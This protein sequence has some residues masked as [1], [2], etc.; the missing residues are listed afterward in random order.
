MAGNTEFHYI[1]IDVGTGSARACVIDHQGNIVGLASQ[2]IKTWQP[3]PEFYEQSTKDIWNTSVRQS[4][5]L[6]RKQVCS[7]PVSEVLLSMPHAL[8]LFSAKRPTIR[9]L[10]VAQNAVVT[11]T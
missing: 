11:R 3:H 1:G 9:S 10:W 2:S 6:Y 5:K 8:W 4:N 7:D